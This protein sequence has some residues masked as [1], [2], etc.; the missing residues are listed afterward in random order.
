MMHTNMTGEEI[1]AQHLRNLKRD[2]ATATN[3]RNAYQAR[4][5]ELTKAIEQMERD[6]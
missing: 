1:M 3:F 5:D 4:V 2:L 6:K